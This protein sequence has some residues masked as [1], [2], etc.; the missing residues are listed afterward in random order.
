MNGAFPFLLCG[1]LLLSQCSADKQAPGK[2]LPP[3]PASP[4]CV[5]SR[6][7][8]GVHQVTPFTY[9]GTRAEALARLIAVLHSMP[10]AKMVTT[11]ENYLHFEFMSALFRFVDDVEFLFDDGNKVIQVRSASRVGFY[12][13]GVNRRRVE[14][15]R[16]HFVAAGKSDG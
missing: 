14:E 5:S 8:S 4:N 12:D 3:C 16:K 15:I 10:R 7:P 9:Q 6:E 2:N 13:F 11:E 1:V